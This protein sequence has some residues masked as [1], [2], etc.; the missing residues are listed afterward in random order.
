MLSARSL[1]EFT[2]KFFTTETN[3]LREY[4]QNIL[5]SYLYQLKN[6][7]QMAFKG[8]TALRLLYGSPRFS[9]DL[10]FS[11]DLSGYFIEKLLSDLMEKIKKESL[12]FTCEESKT[13]TGGYFA[14]YRFFI[15]DQEIAIE[16][17]ISLRDTT[18]PEPIL[19]TT[20]LLPSYQC[21]TLPIEKLVWEKCD[22][23]L[24]RKKPRDFFDLYFL[25]RERRGLPEIIKLKAKLL[26][27]VKKLEGRALRNELK[28]LLP[29][30]HQG[31]LKDFP[32]LLATEL[33]RL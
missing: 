33:E 31:I 26:K 16:F 11:S 3:V 5:L 8:G 13:T 22:A 18:K 4:L 15:L 14:I 7:N 2:K 30:T 17:N 28:L 32:R 23:L 9:E 29:V 10:D 12:E 24:R 21:L 1:K 6:S 19:V 20:P 27:E 25:L